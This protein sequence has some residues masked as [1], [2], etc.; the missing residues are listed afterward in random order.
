[1]ATKFRHSI[2]LGKG[3]KALAPAV[4]ACVIIWVARQFFKIEMPGEVGVAL[5]SML[6]SA[7]LYTQNLSKHGRPR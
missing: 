2:S 4:P 3:A 7:M 6:T 1:M 5:S